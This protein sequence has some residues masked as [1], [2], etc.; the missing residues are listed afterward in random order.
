MK[1]GR[2]GKFTACSNY[3]N[4]KFVKREL[5][6]IPCPEKDCTGEIVVRRTKRG[7]TFYGGS[8][9]PDCKFTAWDKQV[10]EACPKCVSSILL[11]KFSKK[12]DPVRY[13]PKEACQYKRAVAY[14]HS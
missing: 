10:A 12:C 4:C 3:P 9:Y 11:D 6:G 14:H 8:R 2:F 1:Y 5:L 7:K 13:S